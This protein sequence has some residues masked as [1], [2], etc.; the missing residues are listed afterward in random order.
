MAT[1]SVNIPALP[2]KLAKGY[3]VQVAK[4]IVQTAILAGAAAGL[5]AAAT[6]IPAVGAHYGLSPIVTGQLVGIVG[7]VRAFVSGLNSVKVSSGG[8][9]A[10]T[11]P[12]A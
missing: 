1:I 12:S 6:Q 4:E 8:A 9:A 7:T 5:T 2:T 3:I 10:P 11:P